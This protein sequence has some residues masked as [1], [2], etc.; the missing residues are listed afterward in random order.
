MKK[1][2]Q[3]LTNLGAD[4]RPAVKYV[5]LISISIFGLLAMSQTRPTPNG[6][7]KVDG[8]Y[9][10]FVPYP[11][12]PSIYL[13]DYTNGQWQGAS[14]VSTTG[15]GTIDGVGLAQHSKAVWSLLGYSRG[16]D[17]YIHSGLGLVFDSTPSYDLKGS[18]GAPTIAHIRD[19]LWVVAYNRDAIRPHGQYRSLLIE[20]GHVFDGFTH[21]EFLDEGDPVPVS[22][23]LGRPA[24]AHHDG[25]LVFAWQYLGPGG[26]KFRTLAGTVEIFP[27]TDHFYLTNKVYG[28]LPS[29]PLPNLPTFTADPALAHDGVGTFYAAVFK[30]SGSTG[31][32]HDSLFIYSSPDGVNWAPVDFLSPRLKRGLNNVSMAAWPNG[33]LLVAITTDEIGG[34]VGM[35]FR[36][37][38][39]S[40]TELNWSSVFGGARPADRSFSLIRS[41]YFE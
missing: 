35:V 10:G 15:S 5:A 6:P 23:T 14:S 22:D 40:W 1:A 4:L 12:P 38:N 17:I 28:E 27:P 3:R 29:G 26:R 31:L 20:T 36:R 19:N 41:R 18:V 39:E 37:R 33:D 11:G 2:I 32:T 34:R 21:P 16:E 13:R 30:V 8:Y 25:R 9:L 24:V 7:P